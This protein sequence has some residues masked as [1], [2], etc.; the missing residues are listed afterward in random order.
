[1]YIFNVLYNIAI[2]H[3]SYIMEYYMCSTNT[4]ESHMGVTSRSFPNT[5]I[6]KLVV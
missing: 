5:R 1:M 2:I 3:N 6:A 4:C